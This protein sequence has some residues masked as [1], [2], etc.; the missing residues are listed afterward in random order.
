MGSLGAE[1]EGIYTLDDVTQD[2]D[3]CDAEGASIRGVF[4]A[5]HLVARS[6]FVESTSGARP[7]VVIAGCSGLDA[8]RTLGA[9]LLDDWTAFERLPSYLFLDAEPDGT[10]TNTTVFYGTSDGTTCHDGGI[11]LLEL[12]LD[13]TALRIEIRSHITDYPAMNGTCPPG[14]ASQQGA[15]A[16]CNQLRVVTGT[17][18][19]AL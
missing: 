12:S 6:T 3:S 19:E 4:D 14:L 1:L 17:L 8:C 2:S 13:G 7:A 15:A 10:L 16:P 11:Q 18:V 9:A 5:T